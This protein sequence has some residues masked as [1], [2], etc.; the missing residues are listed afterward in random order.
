[1][2]IGNFYVGFQRG[3]PVKLPNRLDLK[4][5]KIEI[6]SGSPNV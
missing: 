2:F 5:V 6:K 3:F 4:E 1:M